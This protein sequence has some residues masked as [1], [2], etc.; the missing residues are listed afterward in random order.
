LLVSGA[1]FGGGSLTGVDVVEGGGSGLCKVR[2][3]R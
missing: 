2:Y 3:Q 1:T